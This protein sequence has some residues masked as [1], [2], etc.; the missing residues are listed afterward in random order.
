VALALAPKEGSEVIGVVGKPV[1]SLHFSYAAD[2]NSRIYTEHPDSRSLVIS[3]SFD[4][5]LAPGS[6]I[7]SPT[8]L[9][10]NPESRHKKRRRACISCRERKT[11]C[12][13]YRE[14]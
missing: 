11:K 12:D 8:A 3:I 7:F 14:A 2:P 4:G 13:E 5:P 9:L 1:N 6:D 10:G